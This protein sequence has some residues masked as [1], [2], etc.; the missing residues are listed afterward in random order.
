MLQQLQQ[1]GADALIEA[2]AGTEE[3]RHQWL[4]G[5]AEVLPIGRPAGGHLETRLQVLHQ[6]HQLVVGGR[7]PGQFC[8]SAHVELECMQVTTLTVLFLAATQE[9]QQLAHLD[10]KS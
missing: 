8:G 6:L 1:R 10:T 2:A 3:E 9:H 4:R 5:K 7:V